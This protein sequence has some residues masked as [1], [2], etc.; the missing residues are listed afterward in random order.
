MDKIWVLEQESGVDGEVLF[1]VTPC[2]NKEVAE[3]LMEV[4]KREIFKSSHFAKLSQDEIDDFCDIEE[5]E[6]SYFII[7]ND[8]NFYEQINITEMTILKEVKQ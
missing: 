8:E 1:D 4:R 6:E 3:R 2:S 7:D 5:T